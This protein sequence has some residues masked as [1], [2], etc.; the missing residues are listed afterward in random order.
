METVRTLNV[1]FDLVFKLV[2]ASFFI[3]VTIRYIVKV[4][5]IRHFN[6]KILAKKHELDTINESAFVK[7]QGT[8]LASVLKP[9][10]AAYKKTLED[11]YDT[12]IM[13]RQFL[14]DELPLLNLVK[15]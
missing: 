8:M 1:I 2:G 11:E 13:E 5:E 4:R 12:M 3:A 10:I 9:R 15:G 6:K 14:V 7:K